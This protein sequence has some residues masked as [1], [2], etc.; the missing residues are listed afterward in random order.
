MA[1]TITVASLSH[2]L[3]SIFLRP[4]ASGSWEPRSTHR[5]MDS[6]TESLLD[7]SVLAETPPL[8]KISVTRGDKFD[9]SVRQ[10]NDGS[11]AVSR[12]CNSG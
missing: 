11:E 5:L 10:K 9:A 3:P 12:A 6:R 7:F 2:D 8:F 4:N 1:A